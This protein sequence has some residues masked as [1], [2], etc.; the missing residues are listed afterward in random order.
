LQRWLSENREL[1]SASYRLL[2][3]GLTAMLGIGAAT[4]NE[5]KASEGLK[6]VEAQAA[7]DTAKAEKYGAFDNIRDYIV[8]VERRKAGCDVALELYD[9]NRT[10]SGWRAVV[11][12]CHSS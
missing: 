3:V 5:N 7:V 4:L 1:V 6:L 2:G 10:P 11:L 12:K 9:E 8:D